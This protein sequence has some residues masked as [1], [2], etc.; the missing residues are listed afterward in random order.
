MGTPFVLAYHYRC[1]TNKKTANS[2]EAS[3]APPAT[4][5]QARLNAVPESPLSARN[6][7]KAIWLRS[8]QIRRKIICRGRS[9]SFF[10]KN[11]MSQ[12]LG[13]NTFEYFCFDSRGLLT[14]RSNRLQNLLPFCRSNFGL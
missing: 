11:L 12:R 1:L 4:I 2:T 8:E 6:A 3:N 10:K 9:G 5:G 13:T 14:S 7:Y